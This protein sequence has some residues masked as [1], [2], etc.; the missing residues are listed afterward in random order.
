MG[1]ELKTYKNIRQLFFVLCLVIITTYDLSAQSLLRN[2]ARFKRM[3]KGSWELVQISVNGNK[4]IP[5]PFDS[6]S[7]LHVVNDRVAYY[8][9]SCTNY[10]GEI[11]YS[12]ISI[13]K[14]VKSKEFISFKLEEDD[15]LVKIQSE[16][17]DQVKCL[18]LDSFEENRNEIF[19][20]RIIKR[21]ARRFSDF[22]KLSNFDPVSAEFTVLTFKEIK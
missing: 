18:S 7:L 1:Q 17:G 6:S 20:A 19:S 9:G 4:Q 13:N 21:R 3:L 12:E 15:G 8:E 10:V 16:Q 5:N 14:R 2:Q 11:E 22:L